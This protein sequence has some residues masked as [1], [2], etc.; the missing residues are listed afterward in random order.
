MDS[1]FA[2]GRETME[3]NQFL[4]RAFSEMI[5]GWN[6]RAMQD[7][8]SGAIWMVE[9]VKYERWRELNRQWIVD[10]R[11]CSRFFSLF[12]SIFVKYS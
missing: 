11:W 5:E 1:L 7:H 4:L 9:K 2:M 6:G 3:T 12:Q 10:R 8:K